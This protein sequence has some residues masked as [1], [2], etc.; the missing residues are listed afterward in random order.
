MGCLGWS[1]IGAG[2]L[3]TLVLYVFLWGVG[4]GMGVRRGS[5]ADV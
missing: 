5:S 2:V 3:V 4:S 1:Y